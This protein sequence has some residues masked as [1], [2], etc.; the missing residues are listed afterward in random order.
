ADFRF[1]VVHA[2]YDFAR[3]QRDRGRF[4]EAVPIYRRAIESLTRVPAER[5][6]AHANAE[7]LRRDVLERDLAD[8]ERAPLVLGAL[9]PLRT[10]PTPDACPLLL[11]RVR[12]LVA[13]DKP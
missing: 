11:S 7:F 9:A 1:F 5:V 13:R 12:L 6:A 2:Q 3:L 10:R 8:C 4:S